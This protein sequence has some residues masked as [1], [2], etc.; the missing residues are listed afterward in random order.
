MDTDSIRFANLNINSDSIEITPADVNDATLV[1]EQFQSMFCTSAVLEG[2]Y[3]NDAKEPDA[4][5]RYFKDSAKQ[6]L[7]DA[8]K[9][10]KSNSLLTKFKAEDIGYG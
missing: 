4:A 9:S 10:R 8:R 3:G 2:V 7:D 6:L 5:S 1:L